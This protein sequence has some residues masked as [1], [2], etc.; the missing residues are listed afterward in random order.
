ML[1]IITKRVSGAVLYFGDLENAGG[2][3][4]EWG[5]WTQ[6]SVWVG[7]KGVFSVFGSWGAKDAGVARMVGREDEWKG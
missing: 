2:G 6:Y 7:V 4:V 1:Y 3:G 5:A